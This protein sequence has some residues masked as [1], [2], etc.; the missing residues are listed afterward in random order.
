MLGLISI[1]DVYEKIYRSKYTN[2]FYLKSH[3]FSTFFCKTFTTQQNFND[4]HYRQTTSTII[5]N[6]DCVNKQLATVSYSFKIFNDLKKKKKHF[7]VLHILTSCTNI[8]ILCILI[9]LTKHRYLILRKVIKQKSWKR[10]TSFTCE[11]MKLIL[12]TELNF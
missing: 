6:F 12:D 4:L 11:P 5:F 1:S 7:E 2:L 8:Y 9:I 3:F 10:L